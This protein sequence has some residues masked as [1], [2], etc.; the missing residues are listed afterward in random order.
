M[1][2]SP[3]KPQDAL[4]D[5]VVDLTAELD[6]QPESDEGPRSQKPAT[7]EVAADDVDL[8]G[9]YERQR[10]WPELVDWLLGQA[11]ATSDPVTRAARLERAS[12][13]F[14][15]ELR[16]LEGAYLTQQAAVKAAASHEK[17]G[18]LERLAFELGRGDELPETFRAAAAAAPSSQAAAAAW[19][20]LA[21]W[22][23]ARG[24]WETSAKAAQSALACAPR[25][26]FALGELEEAERHLSRWGDLARTLNRRLALW[27]QDEA[28]E[29]QGDVGQR[30]AAASVWAE[31]AALYE[32]RLHDG[33]QAVAAC[34][35]ALALDPG[36]T[37]VWARLER[38]AGESG[39]EVLAT[40]VL[41]RRLQAAQSVS[42]HTQLALRLATKWHALGRLDEATAVLEQA[43]TRDPGCEALYEELGQVY[44]ARGC[45]SQFVDN[46]RRH[47]GITQDS[48]LRGRLAFETG[49]VLQNR[50]GQIDAARAAYVEALTHEPGH[51]NARRGLMGVQ[52]SRGDLEALATSLWELAELTDDLDEKLTCFTEA[53]GL[54]REHLH[55]ASRAQQVE[56]RLWQLDPGNEVV[57]ALHMDEAAARGA[58]AEVKFIGEEALGAKPSRG[59]L[60]A[61]VAEAN[62]HLGELGAALAGFDQVDAVAASGV[63][64]RLCWIRALLEA[65]RA[66]QAAA[67]ARHMAAETKLSPSERLETQVALGQAYL[68]TG[69][70]EAALGAFQAAL[71]LAPHHLPALAGVSQA[72]HATGQL[73][74]AV[75]W[76]WLAFDHTSDEGDK[77]DHALGIMRWLRDEAHDPEGALTVLEHARAHLPHAHALLHALL[78]HHTSRRNWDGALAALQELAQEATGVT[79]AKYLLAV[80]KIEQHE[81]KDLAAALAAF[82]ATLD[83]WPD[84]LATERRIEKLLT[85]QRD[86]RG[87][88]RHLRRRLARIS[89][90]GGDQTRE[91]AAWRALARLYEGPLGNPKSAVV[92]LEVLAKLDGEVS[93]REALAEAHERAG[94]EGLLRAIGVHRELLAEARSA[95][96]MQRPLRALARLFQQTGASERHANAVGAL[97]ALGQ[98]APQEELQAAQASARPFAPPGAI[99]RAS[100]WAEPLLHPDVSLPLSS[101]FAHAAEVVALAHA[102]PAK[103]WGLPAR[104]PRGAEE[105]LASHPYLLRLQH[106]AAV[107]GVAL[108]PVAIHETFDGLA[109][110]I[111][112]RAGRSPSWTLILGRPFFEPRSDRA[113]A[114]MATRLLARLRPEF[115]LTWPNVVSS[116]NELRAILFAAARFA[117]VPVKLPSDQEPAV[118]EYAQHF[119]RNLEPTAREGLR[120]AAAALPPDT[121]VAPWWRGVALTLNRVGFLIC[122]DL[123]TALGVAAR[124]PQ[125]ATGASSLESLRDLVVWATSDAYA[126]L[127]LP[128]G[129]ANGLKG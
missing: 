126:H 127:A 40:R 92:A 97:V 120:A 39:R 104:W 34:E 118:D 108:P 69:H 47:A 60:L 77:V 111:V 65:G 27:Q 93:T 25:D 13:V 18:E 117:G 24:A 11:D 124:E 94:P 105:V 101:L 116:P 35:K 71:G 128:S 98:A 17:L 41:G 58:W 22:H 106:L 85:A 122:G 78:D 64:W 87:L 8:E 14:E 96:E 121:D 119:T 100:A 99:L 46:C 51:L 79:K 72:Y 37:S 67:L 7:Q 6:A 56:A 12:Q 28:L 15:R 114:F 53:A 63:G 10:S 112:I 84:D 62:F 61:G 36:R 43:R 86:A 95:P 59:R 2:E 83:A 50:L 45:W 110:L 5:D 103:A 81:R 32:E 26:E 49:R 21:R 102:Q 52:R 73:A 89:R 66:A 109:D 20:A 16:D 74:D 23:R 91:S 90:A 48:H 88:E 57:A 3:F 29:P 54:L 55:D 30:A 33:E 70:P 82:E 9:L 44:G 38:L 75:A 68:A 76:R 113:F 4:L 42:E 1:P 115:R 123:P 19:T 107:L 125:M 80:G 129:G 31:L